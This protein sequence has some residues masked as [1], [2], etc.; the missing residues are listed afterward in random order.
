MQFTDHTLGKCLLIEVVFGLKL[1]SPA[2]LAATK[3][4]LVNIFI[5]P[6]EPRAMIL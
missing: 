1:I 5:Y 2:D 6:R 4:Y 3:N